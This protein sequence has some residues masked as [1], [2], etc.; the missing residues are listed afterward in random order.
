MP[1]GIHGRHYIE[2]IGKLGRRFGAALLR[3]PFTSLVAVVLFGAMLHTVMAVR[4]P[5]RELI[6]GGPI[7][8]AA[9]ETVHPTPFAIGAVSSFVSDE[10]GGEPGPILATTDSVAATLIFDGAEPV[11][12]GAGRVHVVRAG[13]TIYSIANLYGTNQQALARANRIVGGALAV[14]DELVIPASDASTAAPVSINSGS[15]ASFL[16]N[17]SFIWPVQGPIGPIHGN[18]GRDIPA[19]IGTP[20]KASGPGIV[21]DASYGWNGGYGNRVIIDHGVSGVAAKT[22]YG[23]MQDFVVTVGQQV[24]TGDTIGFV[25]ST[26]RSTGPHVHFEVR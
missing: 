2:E 25:G 26:G 3:W 19:P 14:G 23:H 15:L 4:S 22:L 9:Q 11:S 18:N 17:S 1:M 24:S 16:P 12:H 5:Y 21:I 10:L 20:I 6:L 8:A 7:V 13:E